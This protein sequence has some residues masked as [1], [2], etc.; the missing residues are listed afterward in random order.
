MTEPVWDTSAILDDQGLV[1]S[2]LA[3]LIGY[4]ARPS[5]FEAG[6]Y[7]LYVV[8]A[9]TLIFGLGRWSPARSQ[10]GAPECGRQGVE[11]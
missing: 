10:A 2:L 5:S 6:A 4:R 9:A 7:V 1:G 8:V 11:A 3:G